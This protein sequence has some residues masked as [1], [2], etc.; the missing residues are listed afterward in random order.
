Q[1]GIVYEE[2]NIRLLPCKALEGEGKVIQ[3]NLSDIPFL[4]KDDILSGLTQTLQHYG[5][6]LDVGLKYDAT[7]RVFMGA[8]YALI[9]QTPEK[10]YPQL[11]HTLTWEEGGYFCHA[12]FPDMPTWC[13]Y[14]H[15]EGHTKYA[16][17][18]ALASITCYSC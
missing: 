13:R 16:C 15:A 8:G 18:K 17:P 14:C 9:Q 2:A 6:V 3:L 10:S 5:T 7:W 11:S 12:T 1:N 4:P